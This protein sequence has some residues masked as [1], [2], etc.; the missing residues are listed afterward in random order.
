MGHRVPRLE[1]EAYGRIAPT[2]GNIPMKAAPLP[3]KHVL[4]QDLA[5]PTMMNAIFLLSPTGC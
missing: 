1:F 3:E 4:R 2:V 5:N